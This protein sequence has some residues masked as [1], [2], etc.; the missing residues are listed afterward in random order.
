MMQAFAYR[1]LV[2][3]KDL[4]VAVIGRFMPKTTARLLSATPVKIPSGGT[5]RVQAV[6]PLGQFIDKVDF[7]LTNPPDGIAIKSVTSRSEGTD[8]V[9]ETDAAKIKPGLKGNL[10]LS[11]FTMRSPTGTNNPKATARRVA[12]GTLPAIPFEIVTP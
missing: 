7:E 8:F 6:L 4:Q 5:A 11:A 1:H 9:L 10:I 3:A 2:V 12:L